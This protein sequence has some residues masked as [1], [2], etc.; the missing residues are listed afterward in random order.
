MTRIA[1]FND[2]GRAPHIGCRGVTSGHD[3]MLARL[4]VS[5]AYRSFLGEWVDLA[6][7]DTDIDHA[8]R[9]FRASPLVSILEG[10]DAVVVNGEGTIHHRAGLHLVAILRGAQAMGIPT[11]LVNAV[12]QESERDLE[13]L[14]RLTDFTV[15]DA[16]SSRYLTGLG[17][18]HRVVLD[19]I[20]EAEFS[21]EP[22]LDMQGKIAVTDCQMSRTED[23]GVALT[24]LLTSL[25]DDGV[26]YPLKDVARA[27]AWQHAVA[28]L[29]TA[30]LVVTAR[31]H[32]VCLAAMAGV[33]FVALQSNT[34]KVEGFLEVLP[35]GLRV[36]TDLDTLPRACENALRSA[37]AFR[38]IQQFVGARRPLDTFTALA[39]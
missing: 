39:S 7:A 27:D 34:W 6:D 17:V 37:E 2:T 21:D 23:I 29:R 14:R 22:A 10:V 4:G 8:Q 9:A 38:E 12:I 5:V 35:G 33:P 3:R 32:G 15:R 19:S 13:T 26:Y 31:H 18:P 24:N 1:L 30:R 25:G 28:D 36:C 16:A 20:F 11:Y